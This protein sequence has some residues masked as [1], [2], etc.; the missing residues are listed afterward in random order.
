MAMVFNDIQGVE[1]PRR[2]PTA[3]R[4]SST[5]RASSSTTCSVTCRPRRRTYS[6]ASTVTSAL[7]IGGTSAPLAGTTSF[8]G[9]DYLAIDS[10]YTGL[11]EIVG[12][13]VYAGTTPTFADD[14][15]AVR[16]RVPVARRGGLRASTAGPFTA[17]VEHP[18][19]QFRSASDAH[20]HGLH[21]A[22][23]RRSARG[24]M[25][26]RASA[27]STSPATPSSCWSSR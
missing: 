21:L 25:S 8:N 15:A 23:R 27:S 24:R 10:P 12:P 13:I 9:G 1:D 11:T 26:A 6:G 19:Q 2:S 17:Y 18:E 7:A 4:R 22:D 5:W 14:A 16:A 3:A 20:V